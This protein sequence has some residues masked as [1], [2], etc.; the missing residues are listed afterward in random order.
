MKEIK[1]CSREGCERHVFARG[2]CVS[3]Y[4]AY[5]KSLRR[6]GS[7]LFAFVSTWDE[8]QPYFPGTLAQLAERSGTSYGSVMKTV[9][10]RHKAGEVYIVDH[11]PPSA[12]GGARW[13]RLFALGSGDDHVVSARRKKAYALNGRRKSHAAYV[14]AN[15]PA[16]V[17]KTKLASSW[18][19][20]LFGNCA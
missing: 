6:K 15:K 10:A 8:I 19:D 20:S 18:A 16:K 3:H 7:T 4:N 13:V 11:L 14:R 12:T 1:I 5:I 2:K 9:N 17:K